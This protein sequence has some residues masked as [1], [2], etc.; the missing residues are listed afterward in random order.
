M[1]STRNIVPALAP[2]EQSAPT[3]LA[4]ASS[5]NGLLIINA[6]DWGRDAKTTDRIFEC[7]ALGTVS[8]ASAM[9][10]MED[11]ERAAVLS[12][13]H[14]IDVG[15]HLN[16][17]T[18]F[19]APKVPAGLREHHARVARFLLSN[20]LCQV[21][22]HPGL[23]PS[24]EYLMAA[25]IEEFRRIYGEGPHRVDGHHHMHLCAN[26]LFASLLPAETIARRNFSFQPGEKG[27]A[28]RLY[29]SLI[30]RH[31]AKRHHVTDFFFSLP[32]LEPKERLDRIFAIAAHSVVELETHP[33]NPQ[34]HEFLTGDGI[35]RRTKNI[36]IARGF[37]LPSFAPLQ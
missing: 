29:R 12:R 16:F 20:R 28:N 11:S 10:F 26:V 15:L 14:S 2:A 5:R 4:S 8:S 18:P 27:R 9:V 30:D 21:I 22:Y 33:I 34:E 31:L 35:R 6:D 32:P 25:Q 37:A 19:S 36:S 13:D 17:T 3:Y 7:V 23:T 24:F 1:I